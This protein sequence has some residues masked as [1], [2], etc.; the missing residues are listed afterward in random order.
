MKYCDI[1]QVTQKSLQKP[2]NCSKD[3]LW[4]AEA[5]E[6]SISCS[7]PDSGTQSS[8]VPKPQEA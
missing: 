3:Q 2:C 5:V 7:K 8:K 4:L 6:G 1:Y